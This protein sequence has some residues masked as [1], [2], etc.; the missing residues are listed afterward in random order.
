MF[1]RCY[2]YLKSRRH[3]KQPLRRSWFVSPAVIPR[4]H[5]TNAASARNNILMFPEILSPAAASAAP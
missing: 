1:A 2:E 3:Y 5:F 4:S